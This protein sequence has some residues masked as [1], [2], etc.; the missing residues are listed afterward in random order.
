MKRDWLGVGLLVAV[1]WLPASGQKKES[2]RVANAGK[3]MQE[4]VRIPDDIPQGVL[5]KADCVVVLTIRAQVCAGNWR[6]LC[7]GV[8]TCRVGKDFKG[9]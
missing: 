8:V 4:I 6:E 2:D 5:D 3:T 9:R 1:I 7:A